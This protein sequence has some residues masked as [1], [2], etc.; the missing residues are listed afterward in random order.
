MALAVQSASATGAFTSS[1]KLCQG[2]AAEEKGNWD[3]QKVQRIIYENVGRPGHYSQVVGMDQTTGE[4]VF[5]SREYSVPLAPFSEP[6][7][8]TCIPSVL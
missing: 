4:C 2:T 6:V 3:C 8:T 5:T 7:S 1:Q